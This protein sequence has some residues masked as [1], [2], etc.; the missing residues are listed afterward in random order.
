M[1]AKQVFIDL[2]NTTSADPWFPFSRARIG[3]LR[4]LRSR[5]PRREARS[6]FLHHAQRTVAADG[7]HTDRVLGP[8]D[9]VG[10]AVVAGEVDVDRRGT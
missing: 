5:A 10:I 1:S 8:V 2:N 4:G 9:D 7:E 6:P 3:G